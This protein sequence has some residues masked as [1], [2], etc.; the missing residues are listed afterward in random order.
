[1]TRP[2]PPLSVS[3]ASCTLL[4]RTSKPLVPP[5]VMHSFWPPLQASAT[6]LP[7]TITF[8]L[9]HTRMPDETVLYV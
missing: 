7:S 8:A 3:P 4:Y 2:S 6:S 9:F 5:T 1:M